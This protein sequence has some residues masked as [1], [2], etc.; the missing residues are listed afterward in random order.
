MNRI[1]PSLFSRLFENLFVPFPV[2]SPRC[3]PLTKYSIPTL[4]SHG[5]SPPLS[6]LKS[7]PARLNHLHLLA[8]MA[9]RFSYYYPVKQCRL[10]PLTPLSGKCFNGRP[11][12]PPHL[13]EPNSHPQADNSP[14][15]L[16]QTPLTSTRFFL[17]LQ[18][19]K[20][21]PCPLLPWPKMAVQ[22]TPFF[23]KASS[24]QQLCPTYTPSAALSCSLFFIPLR[25]CPSVLNL[26]SVTTSLPFISAFVLRTASP[27]FL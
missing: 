1:S 13:P 26:F 12:Y 9:W 17:F 14:C 11:E 19:A 18:S 27:Y 7:G 5:S 20:Y 3:L 2:A 24:E 22:S 16:A 8:F 15:R 25:D 6:Q 21:F 4:R 10:I 23:C